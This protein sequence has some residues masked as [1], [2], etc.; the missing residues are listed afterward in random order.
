MTFYDQSGPGLKKKEKEKKRS[1]VLFHIDT[2]LMCIVFLAANLK[3]SLV[4]Q[5]AIGL[6]FQTEECADVFAMPVFSLQNQSVSHLLDYVQAQY[7]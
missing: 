7:L 4:S 3:I 1:R 2:A 5:K 6:D